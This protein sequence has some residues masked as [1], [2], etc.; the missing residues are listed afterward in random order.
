MEN[1]KRIAEMLEVLRDLQAPAPLDEADLSDL[2]LALDTLRVREW[3]T[4]QRPWFAWPPGR[5]LGE[6]A[7]KASI[8][9]IPLPGGP[10][11]LLEQLAAHRDLEVVDV[12]L[13][14]DHWGLTELARE[15]LNP[16]F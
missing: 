6:I 15:D 2:L 10:E 1:K 3:L 8:D 5:T 7:V 9:S 11:W 12:A 14:Q 16:P 13:G 4:R